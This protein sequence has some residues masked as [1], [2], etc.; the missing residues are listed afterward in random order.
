MNVKLVSW[1]VRGLNSGDKRRFEKSII[2]NWKADIVCLQESK[3]EGE[4]HDIIKE[5]G[6]VDGLS[7]LVYK[8]MAL[9][10]AF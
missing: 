2:S 1:N 5:I 6:V 9:G 8:K 4:I 7:M 10:W 3:L